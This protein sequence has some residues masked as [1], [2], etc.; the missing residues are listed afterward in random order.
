MNEDSQI[1]GRISIVH[2]YCDEADVPRS[3]GSKGLDFQERVKLMML[4]LH[5]ARLEIKKLRILALTA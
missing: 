2:K 3:S 1:A 4:E 5:M